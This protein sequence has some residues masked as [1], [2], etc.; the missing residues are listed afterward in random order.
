[1]TSIAAARYARDL[2]RV[3]GDHP[4][5]SNPLDPAPILGAWSNTN[6][7]SWG[8]SYAGLT[9][10]DG[11]VAMHAIAADPAGEPLDWGRAAVAKLFTAGPASGQVCGYLASFD[12][13]HARTYL[14]AN[15][16]YG[17]TV[18]AAF[19][20]FTDGSGRV[21]YFSREFFYRLARPAA[22]PSGVPLDRAADAG[23][24]A[25]AR[26]DDRLPMLR[27]GIDPAPLLHRWRNA[28]ESTRGIAEISCA[29]QDG[30][31]TVRVLAVGPDK[32]IDWGEAEA[33]PYADITATGSSRAAVPAVVDGRPTPHYAD[34]TATDTGPA[35][36]ATYDHGFERVHLQA[37]INLGLLVV[38]MFTEF[39]DGSGR[40]D[41]FHREVFVRAE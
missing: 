4:V 34:V 24:V 41:Y 16:G 6:Q 17:L 22:A 7:R 15:T 23:P 10:G 9:R 12:L 33:M 40:A 36:W 25:V 29:L 21:D 5:P 26:G 13:G 11:E 28:D 2:D 30:Q 31:L 3:L 18:I 32:P 37:R 14:Q 20:S 38:A 39:T 27:A 8:I 35:F 19:T 1:M